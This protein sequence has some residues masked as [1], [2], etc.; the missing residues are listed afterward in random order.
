MGTRAAAQQRDAVKL[1]RAPGGQGQAS[2]ALADNN[3][4]NDNNDHF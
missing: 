3:D 2:H 4:N 1:G